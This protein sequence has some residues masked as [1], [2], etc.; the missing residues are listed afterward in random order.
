MLFYNENSDK[1]IYVHL[2]LYYKQH[3]FL[4]GQQLEDA[5]PHCLIHEIIFFFLLQFIVG[6]IRFFFSPSINA[7]MADDKKSK[8]F[9]L[10]SVRLLNIINALESVIFLKKLKKIRSY[11][12]HDFQF[13]A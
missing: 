9:R 8:Y 6:D 7:V 13:N 1:Q 10:E 11:D 4:D 2:Y 3:I 12:L 5:V